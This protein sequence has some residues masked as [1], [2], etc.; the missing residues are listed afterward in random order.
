M[1]PLAT[2]FQERAYSDKFNNFVG[3][4]IVCLETPSPLFLSYILVKLYIYTFEM[5][6][7]LMA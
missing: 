6:C 4:P 3:R 7:I 5:R 1:T 2:F